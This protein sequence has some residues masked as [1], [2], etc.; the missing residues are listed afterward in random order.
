MRT[1]A[2]ETPTAERKRSKAQKHGGRKALPPSQV[3]ATRARKYKTALEKLDTYLRS[4]E[5]TLTGV[6]Q[7]VDEGLRWKW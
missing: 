3:S 1:K 6:Q 4:P 2:R 5:A 7:V